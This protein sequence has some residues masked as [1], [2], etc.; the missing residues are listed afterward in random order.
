MPMLVGGGPR[1]G[2]G[3]P[4][5]QNVNL[6]VALPYSPLRPGRRVVQTLPLSPWKVGQAPV[7]ARRDW[8]M[9]QEQHDKGCVLAGAVV[10]VR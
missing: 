5:R 3:S 1:L 4:A 10:A 9:G 7:V 2:R 6:N 8:I